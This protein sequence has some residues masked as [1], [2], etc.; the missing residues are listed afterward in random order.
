M[1]RGLGN[2]AGQIRFDGGIAVDL[3][4]GQAHAAGFHSRLQLLA[5]AGLDGRVVQM[6]IDPIHRVE[7]AD[8]RQGGLFA[9]ACYAGDIVRAVPHQRFDLVSSR[10]VT[11]YFSWISATP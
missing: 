10:G 11:P 3:R 7:L 9:D 6:L 8:E 4:Q 5:H 1:S 2:V